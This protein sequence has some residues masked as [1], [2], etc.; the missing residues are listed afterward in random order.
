MSNNSFKYQIGQLVTVK[1][2]KNKS[3]KF[4][5]TYK[6]SIGEDNVY[7]LARES[8]P[9]S[10]EIFSESQIAPLKQTWKEIINEME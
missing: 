6:T 4:I 10:K 8:L 7:V 1:S 9:T 2:F 5:I 3:V